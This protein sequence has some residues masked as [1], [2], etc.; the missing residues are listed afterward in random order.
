MCAALFLCSSLFTEA[1]S[2]Q[3][4]CYKTRLRV[5]PYVDN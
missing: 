2:D 3:H 4:P 1:E 5:L